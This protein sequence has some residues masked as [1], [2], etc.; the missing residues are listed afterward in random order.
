M[1]VKWSGIGMVDG[2]GKINGSVASKNRAGAYVRT[3]VTPSNPRSASQSAVRASFSSISSLWRNLTTANRNSWNEAVNNWTKTDVF[4]DVKTPSGYNLFMRLSTPLLNTF[5]DVIIANY[6]PTPVSFPIMSG[7][8]V[9]GQ[10]DVNNVVTNISLTANVENAGGL[11]PLEYAVRIYATPVLSNGKSF[12]KNDYRY[13][14]F[15]EFASLSNGIFASYSAKFGQLNLDDN[16]W[17][18]VEIIA[19]AT[20]QIALVGDVK[21]LFLPE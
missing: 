20:G 15:T 5:G 4:G 16:V 12:T 6:A 18:K 2:R 13:L 11:N 1:K 10:F 17:F 7:L 14:K 9:T 3:K 21:M 19:R 8:L